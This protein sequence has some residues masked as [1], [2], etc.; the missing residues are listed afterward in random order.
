[1][2]GEGRVEITYKELHDDDT[3]LICRI[4]LIPCLESS[5]PFIGSQC[6]IIALCM[7]CTGYTVLYII[8]CTVQQIILHT[9][10]IFKTS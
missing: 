7:V 8:C 1:M 6:L 3:A 9:N 2:R 4:Q 5:T 10:S